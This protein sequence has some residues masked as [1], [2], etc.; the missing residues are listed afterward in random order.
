MSEQLDYSQWAVLAYDQAEVM[1]TER[2]RR[3]AE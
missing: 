1:L 3:N 2:N